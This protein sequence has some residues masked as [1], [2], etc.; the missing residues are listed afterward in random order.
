MRE[1][2][3]RVEEMDAIDVL[4][5]DAATF[6]YQT[7]CIDIYRDVEDP[8]STK[9]GKIMFEPN[10]SEPSALIRNVEFIGEDNTQTKTE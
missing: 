9:L 10:P 1:Q 5:L 2:N 6:K 3:A 7:N 8:Y 4:Q